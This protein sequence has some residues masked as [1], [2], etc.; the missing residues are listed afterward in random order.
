MQAEGKEQTKNGTTQHKEWSSTK[1][2][3]SQRIE[4]KNMFSVTLI[5]L[6]K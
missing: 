2:D 4:T 6:G 1:M 3:A 5:Q